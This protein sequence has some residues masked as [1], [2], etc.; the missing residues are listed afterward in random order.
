MNTPPNAPWPERLGTV[1]CWGLLLVV[2]VVGGWVRVASLATHMTHPDDIGVATAIL[3][4]KGMDPAFPAKKLAI[5]ADDYW[6]Y[7][8]VKQVWHRTIGRTSLAFPVFRHLYTVF[9]PAVYFTYAPLQFFL[10]APLIQPEQSL[11][12]LLFW[13]RLPSALASLAALLLWLAICRQHFTVHFLPVALLSTTML[14]CSWT[15]I[16]RGLQMDNFSFGVCGVMGLLYASLREWNPRRLRVC[17]WLGAGAGL[18]FLGHYQVALFL[19][20]CVLACFWRVP[21]RGYLG[22]RAAWLVPCA[23]VIGPWF[24]LLVLKKMEH[25]VAY[26][27]GL[28]DE[29]LFTWSGGGGVLSGIAA[30]IKFFLGNLSLIYRDLFL[31]VDAAQ[32]GGLRIV[33]GLFGLCLLGMLA[34]IVRRS[35]RCSRAGVFLGVSVGVWVLLV[36]AQRL[37]FGPSKHTFVLLPLLLF[38]TAK[39]FEL[40]CDYA[41]RFARP[42]AMLA[43]ASILGI[44]INGYAAETASRTSSY[45][46]HEQQ[47]VDLMSRAQVDCVYDYSNQQTLLYLPSI[48]TRF[49]VYNSIEDQL[50]VTA[51]HGWVGPYHTM[52]PVRRVAFVGSEPVGDVQRFLFLKGLARIDNISADL[53]TSALY[54]VSH[55]LVSTSPADVEYSPLFYI[56]SNVLHVY[57]F[58]L[59]LQASGG[60]IASLRSQ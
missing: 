37:S 54:E 2:F 6:G 42:I 1:L 52:P 53:T 16:I 19:P 41:R 30:A 60:E 25:S 24:I 31:F 14:A 10:T 7:R 28:A 27:R 40:L 8:L 43:S 39:G 46:W 57:I 12:E 26:G 36:A 9:A 4:A 15:H 59:Q 5:Q 47:L 29:F 22:A 17:L 18:M 23:A 13:G 33:Q 34:M 44:F 20:G 38:G 55:V 45:I 32:L 51:H 3:R 49:P 58:E 50:A 11:R 48:Y 35:D 56:G 21:L